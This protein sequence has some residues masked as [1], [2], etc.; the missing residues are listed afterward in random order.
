MFFDLK[1]TICAQ[2]TPSGRGG[3]HVIRVS[4]SKCITILKPLFTGFKSLKNI[5]SHRVYY[6]FI[7]DPSSNSNLDEVLV[8]YFAEGKSF[9]SEETIEISCHGNPVIVKSILQL[10]IHNGCRMADRGEFTYRAFK[11]GR[12]S[13]PQAEAVLSLIDSNH[14][15]G[16]SKALGLL[17]GDSFRSL[18]TVEKDLIWCVSHL[19]ARIDFSTED[20][21][22]ESH[23][24]ISDKLKSTAILLKSSVEAFKKQS[25]FNK[26]I[27]TL[28]LGPPNAGKSSLFNYLIGSDR[29]IVSPI[30]GTTR[31]YLS[32]FISI[33]GLAFELIDTAGIRLTKED[34]E[35]QGILKVNELIKISDLILFVVSAEDLNFDFLN[36]INGTWKDKKVVLLINK[37]DLCPDVMKTSETSVDTVFSNITKIPISVSSGISLDLLMNTLTELFMNVDYSE[38]LQVVSLRQSD[39]MEGAFKEILEGDKVLAS[40]LGDEYILSHLNR[41]LKLILSISFIENEEIIRDRIFKDFCLGK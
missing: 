29:S 37:I 3:I 11:G 24:K 40:G 31:D 30:A 34:I 17:S 16:V 27:K 2:S 9:T 26:G 7:V 23:Q 4:G 32:E 18:K 8:T 20:I 41:A 28:I 21:E 35:R 36:Q 25:I 22:V 10:L 1:D 38:N 33:N 12:L 13:L 6:G 5:E 15:S 39:A 19:E 14:A